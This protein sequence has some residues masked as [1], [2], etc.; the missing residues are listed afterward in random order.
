MCRPE[1]PPPLRCYKLI[2]AYDGSEFF[3]WQRQSAAR[4]V[5]A[6]LEDAI[7][8]LTGDEVVHLLG[9]SRT[10]TGVHAL[11]QCATFRSRRWNA[12]PA[13]L[14]MALNTRL[15][16]DVVVRSA[17]EVPMAFNPIRHARSKR[18]RYSIY[19][20]RVSDPLVR[21]QA[22]WVKRRINLEAMREAAESLVGHHDFAS[23]QTSGS[24]RKSTL[25]T[26]HAIDISGRESMDGQLVTIEIEA[27]GFLYN[28]ARSITGTLVLAGVARKPVPWVR[29]VLESR[30]R[31]QAGPTAP[32]HGL[33]LLEINYPPLPVESDTCA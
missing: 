33:C 28:M 3:G 27:N 29:S 7:A 17:A 10:D 5:Q 14:A 16:N 8:A 1:Q 22:W 24:P 26:I 6:T 25:R 13:N 2:V 31:K 9:S 4:T 18:Y 32:A 12:A 20:A 23:F 19:A 11:G 30:D 15:P 21:R